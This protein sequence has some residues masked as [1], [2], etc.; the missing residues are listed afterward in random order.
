MYIY[1]KGGRVK[2]KRI[3]VIFTGGTIGSKLEN[4][5]VNLKNKNTYDLLNR[6]CDL[7]C[8]DNI[9]F[10][11]DEPLNMLSENVLPCDLKLI[12]DSIVSSDKNID[13]IIVTYGTDTLSYICSFFALVLNSFKIPVVFISS[14]FPL[15]DKRADGMINFKSAIDFI[16]T[17]KLS[18][19]YTIT[20]NNGIS[21]VHIGTR[22][23]QAEPFT[24]CFKSLRNIPFGKISNGIF[25]R[26]DNLHN[27]SIDDINNNNCMTINYPNIKQNIIYIPSYPFTNYNFL[28][29]KEKPKAVLHGLYHSGTSCINEKENSKYS[30]LSFA[31][32]CLENNIDFYVTPFDTSKNLYSTALEMKKLGIHFLENMTIETCMMKLNIAYNLFSDKKEINDFLNSNIFFER[33]IM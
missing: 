19:V 20:Y 3:K 33:I 32:R 9:K 16:L 24:H 23:C 14:H 17:S 13:G 10:I 8:N 21:E 31:R 7:K 1:N 28:S 25:C 2:M 12:Y 6:Y 18:G 4:N 26:Y 29:F 15:E 30:I 11:V 5:I 22:I 27:P